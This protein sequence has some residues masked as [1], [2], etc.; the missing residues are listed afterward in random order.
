MHRKIGIP[1]WLF[2][3]YQKK[4]KNTSVVEHYVG[5]PPQ[6]YFWVFSKKFGIPTLQNSYFVGG[7]LCYSLSMKSSLTGWYSPDLFPLSIIF[8]HSSLY[9]V[10][11]NI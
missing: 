10:M 6:V 9:G 7:V 1:E 11:Q 8:I 3:I 5:A 2:K 4:S